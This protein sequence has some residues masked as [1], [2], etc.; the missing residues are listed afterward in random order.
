MASDRLG[1]RASQLAEPLTS[2]NKK[3]VCSIVSTVKFLR[4][5]LE[6]FRCFSR[7]E[8]VTCS[9]GKNVWT[10]PHNFIYS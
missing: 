3:P 5:T 9:Y 6:Y 2:S 10:S 4:I 8:L 7:D 1:A